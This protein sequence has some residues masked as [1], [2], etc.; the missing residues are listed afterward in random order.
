M[1]NMF[2]FFFQ[3]EDGIR[4][5]CVTGVQTCALPISHVYKPWAAA[6]RFHA[7]ASAMSVLVHVLVP[8]PTLTKLTPA[9]AISASP[10]PPA[11]VVEPRSGP[12]PRTIGKTL[13][14]STRIVPLRSTRVVAPAESAGATR[15]L[16]A[17]TTSARRR[18]LD[19]SWLKIGVNPRPAGKTPGGELAVRP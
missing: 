2:F 16:R 19:E 8:G 9:A 3:A 10:S 13:R 18:M 15:A 6:A 12:F 4:V 17:R 5:H 11:G 7:I 14:P 1:H